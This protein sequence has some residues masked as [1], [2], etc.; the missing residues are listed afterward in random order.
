MILSFSLD[1]L[2]LV[3]WPISLGNREKRINDKRSKSGGFTDIAIV[4]LQRGLKNNG[5]LK[6]E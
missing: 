4:C 2:I 6:E 3:F 5:I 1:I